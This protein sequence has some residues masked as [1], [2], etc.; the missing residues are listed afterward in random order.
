[1]GAPL[2][3]RKKRQKVRPRMA[4]YGEQNVLWRLW[5]DPATRPMMLERTRRIKGGGR[6]AG[7]ADGSTREE[8][9]R[10]R[11]EAELKAETII[12]LMAKDDEDMTLEDAPLDILEAAKEL[13]AQG[14]AEALVDDDKQ[15]ARAVMKEAITIALMPG[16]KQTKLSAI[17]TVLE[18]TKTKPASTTNTN[19]S[20][21]EAFL[22]ALAGKE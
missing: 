11:A 3:P 4:R 9:E 20:G 7:V 16:N 14:L 8:T 1:M 10:L 18:Y 12:K 5:N 15:T 17:R 22:E 13:K 19:I 2:K 6:P 21:A